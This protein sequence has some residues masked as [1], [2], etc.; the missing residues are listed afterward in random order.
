MINVFKFNSIKDDLY[1][2][3]LEWILNYIES[4]DLY[5]LI[6]MKHWHNIASYWGVVYSF[7]IIY[8]WP[9]K[10]ILNQITY[11]DIY[12]WIIINNKIIYKLRRY[13]ITF[14]SYDED[15]IKNSLKYYWI[16]LKL[17]KEWKENT[18]WI[19]YSNDCHSLYRIGKDIIL[20]VANSKRKYEQI[21]VL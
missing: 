5:K 4:N 18:Y 17:L 13:Q 1:T 10:I 16:E 3:A 7:E 8:S 21:Y 6:S 11:D 12:S 19:T 14:P 9:E 2:N 20:Y 15:N